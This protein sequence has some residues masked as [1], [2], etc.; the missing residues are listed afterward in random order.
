MAEKKDDE[1]EAMPSAGSLMNGVPEDPT[2]AKLTRITVGNVSDVLKGKEYKKLGMKWEILKK[3]MSALQNSIDHLKSYKDNLEANA[4]SL[5]Q[6]EF[7]SRANGILT[8]IKKLEQYA[9]KGQLGKIKLK[10]K[11][12]NITTRSAYEGET[13]IAGKTLLYENAKRDIDAIIQNIIDDFESQKVKMDQDMKEILIEELENFV[14]DEKRFW[15][16]DES[17]K[18]LVTK[19]SY[20]G[21]IKAI[22]DYLAI[23]EDWKKDS[24]KVDTNK[25]LNDKDNFEA[26]FKDKRDHLTKLST[27]EIDLDKLAERTKTLK[28]KLKGHGVGEYFDKIQYQSLRLL[29]ELGEAESILISKEKDIS[30]EDYE[31]LTGKINDARKQ[32]TDHVNIKEKAEELFNNASYLFPENPKEANNMPMGL[33]D[34]VK[35]IKRIKDPLQQKVYSQLL[36]EAISKAESQLNE[37]VFDDFYR[38]GLSEVHENIA[39][40]KNQFFQKKGDSSTKEIYFVSW[41]DCTRGWEIIKSWTENRMHR[42]SDMV[43]GKVGE[44]V[45]PNLNIPLTESL[46]GEFANKVHETEHHEVDRLAGLLKPHDIFHIRHMLQHDVTN[47]DQLK[48]IIQVLSEKG[49]MRWDDPALLKLLNKFQKRIIFDEANGGENEFVDQPRF[50]E[51]LREATSAIWTPDDFRNW[52]SGNTSAYESGKQKFESV[53]NQRAETGDGLKG[54]LKSML[55]QVRMNSHGHKVDAME[56]EQMIHYAIDKGKMSPD[57]RLYYIVQGI[58]SGLLDRKRGSELDSKTLNAYPVIEM[59][60]R[61]EGLTH[62]DIKALARIDSDI[63][64]PGKAYKHYFEAE[65]MHLKAVRERLEKTV[66][67]GNGIDHDDMARYGAHLED[68]TIENLLQQKT[69]GFQLPATGVANITVGLMNYLDMLSFSY[70]DIN[71]KERELSRF[72]TVFLN[73]DNI[74]KGRKYADKSNSYFRWG[75]SGVDTREPRAAGGSIYRGSKYKQTA[76]GYLDSIKG[77]VNIV[78]PEFFDFAYRTKIPDGN[79]VVDFVKKLKS[80]Y[81]EQKIFGDQQDPKNYDELLSVAGEYFNFLIKNDKTIPAKLFAK[82]REDQKKLNPDAPAEFE[83]ELKKSQQRRALQEFRSGKN[84]GV[85]LHHLDPSFH[86]PAPGEALHEEPKWDE[87]PWPKAGHGEHH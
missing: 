74:T 66:S 34:Q 14:K 9:T 36:E 64:E 54:F 24:S 48:A 7:I 15:L 23:I 33:D 76:R 4:Q 40:F 6:V 57:D 50:Y 72:L 67:Q 45:I 28:H 53:C 86:L 62:Q 73:F 70:D 47:E 32:L 43:I 61:S 81:P 80:K 25:L 49:A 21:S 59:Y 55:K 38:K 13:D 5:G 37:K 39:N 46:G 41:Y 68:K 27:G 17:I 12:G 18:K 77:L 26:I 16:E 75:S 63:Y 71:D 3:E 87:D 22:D 35:F 10:N 52:Q 82:V 79:E 42:R 60:A 20:D 2:I 19:Q 56:Y 58:D 8:Q 78:D 30:K 31:R 65:A 29:N 84:S 44:K 83:K 51:R 69:S 11:V 1:V 85:K